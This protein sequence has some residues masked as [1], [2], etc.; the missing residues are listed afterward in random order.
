MCVPYW[1]PSLWLS[2]WAAGWATAWQS[3]LAR[4]ANSLSQTP[5]CRIRTPL[6]TL[7]IETLKP[8]PHAGQ[9]KP[10]AM[11]GGPLRL[12]RHD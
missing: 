10:Y 1:Y 6:L 12:V 5:T 4:H 3:G 11:K 7:H 8:N 2:A 9:P